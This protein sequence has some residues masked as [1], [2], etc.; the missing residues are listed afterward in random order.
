MEKLQLNKAQHTD[1][2]I[3]YSYTYKPDKEKT[4][5]EQEEDI[6]E[7]TAAIGR[8]ITEQLLSS[9]DTS[10]EALQVQGQRLTTKGLQKKHITRR[11]AK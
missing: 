9:H 8:A 3:T 5:L 7:I 4:F 2:S 10:G 6:A 1:G 11:T